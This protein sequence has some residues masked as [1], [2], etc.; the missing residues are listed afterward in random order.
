MEAPMHIRRITAL[1]LS[2]LLVLAAFPF[3]SGDTPTVKTEIRS[4][5]KYGNIEL[6]VK[7]PDLRAKGFDYGDLLAVTVAGETLEMPLCA[8][9]ADVEDGDM[10]CRASTDP[11]DDNKVSIAI[12]TGDMATTL[13]IAQKVQ[14]DEDPGY[15]W[16]FKVPTPVAVTLSVKVKGGYASDMPLQLERTNE[17]AD[18]PAL[19][20]EEFAN[21]REIRTT[22]M[23]EGALYRSSTPVNPKLNRNREADEALYKAGV[24]TVINMVDSEDDLKGYEGYSLTHYSACSV[25]PL[26]MM[27]N[28]TSEDFSAKLKQGLLFLLSHDGPYLFHCEE[29][30]ERTGF[31]C[32]VLECLMGAS[33]EEVV[34]DYMLSYY[35]YYGLEPGSEKYDAV[36]AGHIEKTLTLLL[37]INDIYTADLAASAEKY[38]LSVGLTDA[39]V[40][41]L[42]AA[43]SKSWK[44]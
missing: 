33:A 15:R 37:G 6:A 30:K 24:R 3:A 27:M 17:R 43:L 13:G 31:V 16:D 34:S 29:G 39:D 40:A 25:I 5:N 12:F 36:R 22:G 10:L 26:C 32:A 7:T 2:V 18:Y 9:Y 8:T 19:T 41:A 28:F 35:N 1:V 20:D 42:K 4:I 21:F 14:I 11:T 23:G 38:L 44:E